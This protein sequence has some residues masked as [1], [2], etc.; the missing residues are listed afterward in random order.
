MILFLSGMMLGACI[1]VI[2]AALLRAGR[3]DDL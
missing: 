1:G 2:V 3:D